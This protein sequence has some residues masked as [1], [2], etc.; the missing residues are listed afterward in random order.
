MKHLLS[1]CKTCKSCISFSFRIWRFFTEKFHKLGSRINIEWLLNLFK[2]CVHLIGFKKFVSIQG[3]SMLVTWWT[4]ILLY[5]IFWLL[6]LQVSCVLTR[7]WQSPIYYITN[8]WNILKKHYLLIINFLW[9]TCWNVNIYLPVHRKGP[10]LHIIWV[11][12]CCIYYWREH[13]MW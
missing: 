13:S 7:C 5:I 3:F 12:I 4:W 9:V 2:C 1:V 8:I 11:S 10:S 6:Y